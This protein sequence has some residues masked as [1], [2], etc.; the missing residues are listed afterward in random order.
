MLEDDKRPDDLK[1]S[2]YTM[3]KAIGIGGMLLPALIVVFHGKFLPSIS[4]Y[5]Y[6]KSAVFFIAIL[7][8]LGVFLITYKGYK[9]DK[10]KE[11]ISDNGL[12]IIAGVAA[13]MVVMF[14]TTCFDPDNPLTAP[15]C[16]CEL[17]LF[18]HADKG[19]ISAVH[20]ASAALFFGLMGWMSI[21]R[22]TKGPLTPNKKRKNSAYRFCGY[23]VWLCIA[24]LIIQFALKKFF[25]DMTV[26][27][28][29][30]DVYILET[31]AVFF[32]G[33]SWLI[34][35]EAIGDL[36]KLKERLL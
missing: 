34:K 26:E 19:W 9:R 20:L 27:A 2:Y 29:L 12:T 36:I 1:E 16:G 4:H 31:V 3:R 18:G 25:P 10:K 28:T 13:L 22:F 15:L 17:P 24:L 8:M 33:L 7:A 5:Y 21:S 23:T 32:F 6:T 11:Y 30:Y 14:P 35:G